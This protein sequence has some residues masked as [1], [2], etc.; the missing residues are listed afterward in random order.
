MADNRLDQIVG[1]AFSKSACVVLGARLSSQTDGPGGRNQRG[2]NKWFNLD[3][4]ELE[5]VTTDVAPWRRGSIQGPLIVQV[6]LESRREP[7]GSQASEPEGWC[8][9]VSCFL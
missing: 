7:S 9:C 6:I 2:R 5:C 1:E 3:I 4:P 8:R